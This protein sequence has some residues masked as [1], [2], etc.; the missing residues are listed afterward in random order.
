MNGLSASGLA[1][2]PSAGLPPAIG[3]ADLLG[4]SAEVA[5]AAA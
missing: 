1:E 2:L 3:L 4:L 5:E